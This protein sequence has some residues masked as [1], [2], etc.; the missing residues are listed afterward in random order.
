MS[1]TLQTKSLYI[2]MELSNKKWKLAFSNGDKIREVNVPA[3]SQKGL[4]EAICRAKERLGME[5]D[6]KVLSCY[7]AGRDGFWIHRFLEKEGIENLVVDPA[8][9]EVN[10]RYRRVKTDRLD[11]EKLLRMLMRYWGG[12][13]TIWRVARVPG[14]EEEDERR[15][16]RELERLKKERTGHRNR[17]KS[18]LVLHGIK[19]KPRK[20]YKAYLEW[21]RTWDGKP[22][23]EALR[24]EL[25]RELER[26]GKLNEQIRFLEKMQEAHLKEP[27]TESERK[28]QKLNRLKGVGPVSSWML[29]KEFF[30]WRD[31][32]NRREVGALAGLTG[33]PYDSGDGV[34][35]QGISKAGNKRVRYSTIELA[36]GWLR[37][38]PESELTKWFWKRFGHGNKRMRRIG[39]VALAR[40]LLIALWKYVENDEIPEGAVLMKI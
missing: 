30:G 13:K 39:I 9:I 17:I 31:F 2:A 3:G 40:K 14:E 19:D 35:D 36:W 12:E 37:F 23:P 4:R 20:D 15:L 21:V 1:T 25:G 24:G 38:Q 34:R 5:E 7:E 28:A 29:A 18:L 32:R 11:A 33:T 8:S 22:L 6:T 16:H 10:R 26:L 27:E